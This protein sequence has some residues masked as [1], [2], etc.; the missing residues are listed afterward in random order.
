MTIYLRELSKDDIVILNKWRND[1]D[2]VDS[3]GCP[4]R[5]I[6]VNVDHEWYQNYLRTR[7]SSIRLA[8]CLKESGYMVGAVYLLNI[9]WL[10]KSCEF[11]IWIGDKQVQGKGIGE[12]ATRL[13]IHH[14]FADLNI[15]RIYL[16]VVTDNI[17]ALNL[18]KK[19]GFKEEGVARDAIYK[20][21][22]YKDLV[23]M[24]MLSREY[25]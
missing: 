2:I 3:L 25:C 16:S 1:K 8:I 10:S 11:S 21:G 15:N 17:R 22:Q 5:F 6:D 20:N 14:A 19:V 18:Y 24:G 4:F 12:E 23:L 7:S 9:D 13:A